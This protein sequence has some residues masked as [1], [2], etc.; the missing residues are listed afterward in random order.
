MPVMVKGLTRPEGIQG[1][2]PCNGCSRSRP[3]HRHDIYS[4]MNPPHISDRGAKRGGPDANLQ[5]K[6]DKQ[7]DQTSAWRMWRSRSLYNSCWSEPWLFQIRLTFSL[8]FSCS[9][10]GYRAEVALLR[11]GSERTCA[12]PCFDESPH[13]DG[14]L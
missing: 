13:S 6:M 10:N 1:P 12:S 2:E 9:R 5:T 11:E 14:F 8:R 4:A 3:V 7:S